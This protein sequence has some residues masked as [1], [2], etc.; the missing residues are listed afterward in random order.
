M[1]FNRRH[2]PLVRAS[3]L[4]CLAIIASGSCQEE[5]AVQV[6]ARPV[7]SWQA[8]AYLP[9]LTAAHRL[10]EPSAAARR[11]PTAS[12]KTPAVPLPRP[13]GSPMASLKSPMTTYAS[14]RTDVQIYF[15]GVVNHHL[16]ESLF[17]IEPHVAGTLDWLNSQTLRFTPEK[18]AYDTTYSV[19]IADVGQWTFTTKRQIIFSFDDCPWNA[20]EGQRLLAILRDRHIKAL[21]FPTG[22]CQARYPGLIAA[23][24]ADGHR[25]CNHTYAHPHLTLLTDAQ[26]AA[27]IRGGVH[28]NC[29][30]FRPPWGDWDGTNGRVA[31]IANEQ[32]YQTMTWD[33]D[34]HD[35]AGATTADIIRRI[36]ERGGVILLHMWA[37]N[38]F[39]AM[40]VIPLDS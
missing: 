4:V 27:E 16:V 5:A 20:S 40:K 33:V 21:M 25:V 6:G 22:L 7:A 3:S 11:R 12:F 18:L 36:N 14:P 30:L 32:G 15:D 2:W 23:M 39:E 1:S 24:L 8:R 31:R 38:T 34:P 19:Q 35:W 28:A 26:I 17:Q 37:R 9:T 13:P 29:N 10:I